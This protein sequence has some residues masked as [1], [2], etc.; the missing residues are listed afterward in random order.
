MLV[1]VCSP[2]NGVSLGKGNLPWRASMLIAAMVDVSDLH[3]RMTAC[4][5]VVHGIITYAKNKAS[6]TNPKTLGD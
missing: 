2:L 6:I 4:V 5:C 3:D 1:Y